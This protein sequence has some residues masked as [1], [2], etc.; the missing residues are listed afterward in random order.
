M[1]DNIA[2]TMKKLDNV[3]IDYYSVLDTSEQLSERQKTRLDCPK[4]KRI[5]RK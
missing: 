5:E 3:V 4:Q 1:I 2:Q